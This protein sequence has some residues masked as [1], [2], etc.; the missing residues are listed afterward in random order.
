MGVT[1][2]VPRETAPGERRVALVPEAVAGLVRS[3]HEVL[4]E[5]GAG[6]A[7][8]FTDREYQQAGA[9][10]VDNP[11]ALLGQAD[12]VVKVH[13]PIAR[14]AP[15]HHE[16]DL[17]R[18]GATVVGLLYP[19]SE[20][21]LVERLVARRVTSFALE[22]LPRISRAQSMDALSSQS[23]VVGY[24]SVVR[25]ALALPKFFPLLMT[26]AGTVPPARVL[27]VGAGV[28]GLQAI[29]TA[30]RL[31]A[32]VEA[33]DVRPEVKEQVE[34]LGAVFVGRPRQDAVGEGG[35]AKPLA[36]EAHEEERRLLQERLPQADVVITAALVPGKAAP[37]L[38]TGD[39][40][41]SM[42]P[43]S[44]LVDLAAEQGGN[45]EWTEPGRDI[46]RE[47]ITILGPVN[48]ASS[49]PLEASR[50]YARNISAFLQPL[51]KDGALRL[52]WEDPILQATCVTHDGQR[53]DSV[54]AAK[55]GRGA[56]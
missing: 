41:R 31:G 51:L 35:Y 56:S 55:L 47:G 21:G 50:L 10:L 24:L 1:I 3:G 30:R 54:S 7:A 18:E 45:C 36:A 4:V 29:A 23:T 44:V 27:I 12:V 37:R 25:A 32:Q 16:I 52:D 39:M 48:L 6:E 49:L 40:V 13:R 2:A 17:M 5:Q 28:A 42:R 38:L 53:R 43:G 22:R 33:F 11:Q 9:K 20:A 19:D 46:V 14:A 26:A 8:W 15:Q 34:S